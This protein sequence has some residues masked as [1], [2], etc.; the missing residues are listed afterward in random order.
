[1]RCFDIAQAPADAC[2]AAIVQE[3]PGP[4]NAAGSRLL[5]LAGDAFGLLALLLGNAIGAGD[6]AREVDGGTALRAE[7]PM[8]LAHG[9]ATDRTAGSR[10]VAR[11]LAHAP[12]IVTP[13]R[14]RRRR[15]RAPESRARRA[16]APTG[17]RAHRGPGR[18]R[19]RAPS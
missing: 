14:F 5:G 17:A 15:A 19:P 4:I 7:R 1:M 11:A 13:T 8:P 9:L 10:G 18:A 6:P 12:N 3:G 16:V 2:D